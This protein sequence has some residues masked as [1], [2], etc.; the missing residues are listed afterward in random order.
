MIDQEIKQI[1]IRELVLWTENP[2][3]PI[4][5][6]CTSFSKSRHESRNLTYGLGLNPSA[7]L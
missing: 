3:D 1:N 5:E 6:N 4:D 2:R 7:F